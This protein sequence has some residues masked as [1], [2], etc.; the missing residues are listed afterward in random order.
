[1]I[2]YILAYL[3][4]CIYCRYSI[5]VQ[6]QSIE[7]II[8]ILIYMTIG[9]QIKLLNQV[10]ELVSWQ[11]INY[12]YFFASSLNL[13]S[14][15]TESKSSNYVLICHHS[16]P[17]SSQSWNILY[18]SILLSTTMSLV[19][20][21]F[22][23]LIMIPFYLIHYLLSNKTVIDHFYH[24]MNMLM[25]SY[26]CCNCYQNCLLLARSLVDLFSICLNYNHY[27]RYCFYLN[28]LWNLSS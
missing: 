23:S 5:H 21:S 14:C 1:M 11:K 25:T 7:Y 27:N 16:M 4:T 9:S 28:T 13:S 12:S 19:I 20:H 10:K 17:L 3:H 22:T 26:R 24:S 2:W 6:S 18:S 8:D 15:H